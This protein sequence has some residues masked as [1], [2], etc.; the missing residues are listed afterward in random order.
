MILIV[1]A[2]HDVVHVAN[3]AG[4][5][6]Q[7]HMHDDEGKEAEHRQEVNGARRLP[8]A[9]QLRVPVEAID[10]SRRHG[11]TGQDRQ[12]AEDKDDGEIGDLLQRVVAVK[13]I[14]LRRKVE[15]RIVYPCVPGLQQHKR[16]LGNEPPPLLGIEQHDDE[17][18]TREDEAVN[19]EKVPRAGDADGMPVARRGNDGRDV[20]RI[21]LRGPEPIRRN[22]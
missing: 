9:K 12:R 2:H 18:E 6:D 7:R 14:E 10:C 11:D 22:L 3:E 20:A 15:R 19:V 8:A 13:S 21:V 17:E 1:G 4:H 16:R 5:H